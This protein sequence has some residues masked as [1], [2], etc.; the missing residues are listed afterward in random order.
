MRATRIAVVALFTVLAA[1]TAAAQGGVA[2]AAPASVDS[3]PAAAMLHGQALANQQSVGGRFAGGFAAGFF[4]GLIGTGIAWA[5]A[6]SDDTPVPSTH[7]SQLASSNPNY[8]LAFQQGY[9][10]RLK[11]RRKSSALTGGLVGT[12]VIVTILLATQE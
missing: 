12:A 6:G 11:S 9:S 8:N 7:A 4:L 5:V 2:A 3:A 10:A 1:R